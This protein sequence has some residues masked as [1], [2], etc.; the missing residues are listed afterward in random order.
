MPGASSISF[1]FYS[2]LAEWAGPKVDGGLC[3][4]VS[5]DWGVSLNLSLPA[6]DC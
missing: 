1:N 3:A 6:G 4:G 2:T 5:L